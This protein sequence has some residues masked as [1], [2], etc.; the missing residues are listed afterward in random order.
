MC[1]L[2]FQNG[3]IT[4]FDFLQGLSGQMESIS[5]RAIFQPYFLNKKRKGQVDLCATILLMLG[6]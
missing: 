4:I 2:P 5:Q 3:I 1:E 6:A